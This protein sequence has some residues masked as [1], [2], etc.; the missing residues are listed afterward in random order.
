MKFIA[1]GRLV[2]ATLAVL[3]SAA[4]PSPSAYAAEPAAKLD[5]ARLAALHAP[6]ASTAPIPRRTVEGQRE[7]L[8][9]TIVRFEG[10]IDAVRAMGAVV[11][12]VIGNIA[13]V[14][15]PADRLADVAALPN[16]VSMEAARAQVARLDVS[17][18]A[19]RA[20][21][22]RTGT[23]QNWTGGAGRGVI[24][25]IVDDGS[26]SGT[27]TSANPT[28]PRASSACGISA[29]AARR[30]SRPPALPTAANARR[31]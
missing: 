23:P 30:A 9:Q 8:L 24:V 31:R 19:T 13:T 26:I 17:V 10:S 29:R 7:P 25:G 5:A 18:P 3:V 2:A 15:V 11:R 1:W 21:A 20:D 22:L 16:I 12:S 6:A 14:D 4:L 27:A 28:A